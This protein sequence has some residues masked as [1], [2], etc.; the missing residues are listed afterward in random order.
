M[1]YSVIVARK[2]FLFVGN[3]LARFIFGRHPGQPDP[4]IGTP[5][6]AH[7]VQW[8]SE[9][10]KHRMLFEHRHR[11]RIRDNATET[12]KEE[13]DRRAAALMKDREKRFA[14]DHTQKI[15]C[16]QN[17]LP[18]RFRAVPPPPVRADNIPQRIHC[19]RRKQ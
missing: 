8:N 11:E 1:V 14:I 4:S 13:Q 16:H 5:F 9:L 6:I 15:G 7:F 2:L 12:G 17:G 10:G 19:S 18:R 3:L